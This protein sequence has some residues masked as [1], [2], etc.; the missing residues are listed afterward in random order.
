MASQISMAAARKLL[1]SM[2][3]QQIANV[4][5]GHVPGH[6]HGQ[7]SSWNQ[8]QLQ[9]LQQYA[10]NH[11]FGQP[12]APTQIDFNAIAQALSGAGGISQKQMDA[13]TKGVGGGTGLAKDGLSSAALHFLASSGLLAANPV[14]QIS[15][16]DANGNPLTGGALA[17]AQLQQQMANLA[18]NTYDLQQGVTGDMLASLFGGGGFQKAYG[19]NPF[20]KGFAY[21]P[22]TGGGAPAA[23]AG[24]A[25]GN[26]MAGFG[27]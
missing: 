13:L 7:F 14:Q 12:Q 9:H 1:S 17:V 15:L 6:E 11:G 10:Q 22:S 18:P 8:N 27:Q 5:A 20:R 26:A 3:Q 25:G 2:N 23:A 21:S 19:Y 4:L 16:T 24:S